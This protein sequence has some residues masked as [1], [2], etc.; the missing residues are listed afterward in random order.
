[1]EAA[2]DLVAP[3]LAELA[4]GVEDGQ[5]DLGRG[6]LLLGMLVDRNAAA[7]VDDGDRFVGVDRDLDVVAVAGERLVDGVVDDLVDEVMEAARARRAD[8]HARALAHR[9][10]AAEDRD[11]TGRVVAVLWRYRS[12]A[13]RLCQ[14]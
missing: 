6:A 14:R 9:I 12:S 1:M 5:D 3:A 8:V 10:E 2:G 4:A 13:R 7:V 11:L